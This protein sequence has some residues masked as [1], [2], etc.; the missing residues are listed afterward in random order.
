M[1]YNDANWDYTTSTVDHNVSLADDKLARTLNA[2]DADL[3]GFRGRGGKL[4][5]FHGWADA[6]IPPQNTINYYEAVMSRMG[7]KDADSFVRLFMVPGMEH[8]GNGV[9]VSVFGINSVPR[10]ATPT[11]R[12][13]RRGGALGRA[14]HCARAHRGGQAK[15]SRGRDLRAHAPAGIAAWP[16]TAHYNGSGSTDDAANFTCQ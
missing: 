2:T 14:G 11:T 8:C 5:L 13:R 4:I 3:K 16:K 1:V 6:A 9:G 15:E 10:K 7:A 12:Y